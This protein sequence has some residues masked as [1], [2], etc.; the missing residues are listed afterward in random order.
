MSQV[1][2]DPREASRRIILYGS[3]AAGTAGMDSDF[4]VL[5]VET[6]PVRP[7]DESLRLRKAL[8]S[9]PCPVDL[10][11]MGEREFEETRD[12]IGGIAYPAHQTG[13]TLYAIS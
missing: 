9:F 1:P 11:V 4:D 12:V 10:C 7:M 2:I 5:V 13:L 6:D 8:E 3:Q